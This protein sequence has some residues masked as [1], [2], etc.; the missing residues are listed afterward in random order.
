MRLSV[1]VKTAN[2]GRYNSPIVWSH[3]ILN[4]PLGTEAPV[5]WH[6]RSPARPPQE[7]LRSRS[8]NHG[9]LQIAYLRLFILLTS[10]HGTNING[11]D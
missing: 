9:T 3:L 10:L 5:S 6:L 11:L 4:L 1:T 2:A 8:S 7:V